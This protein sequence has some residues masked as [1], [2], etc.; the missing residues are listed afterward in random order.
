LLEFRA[1]SEVIPVSLRKGIWI[2]K[3]KRNEKTSSICY[4]LGQE[5]FSGVRLWGI[6]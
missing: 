1:V 2:A 6:L 3:P 4:W 5:V